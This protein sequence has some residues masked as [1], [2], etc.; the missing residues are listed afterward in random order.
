[1][2]VDNGVRNI[3]K[4]GKTKERD[5]KQKTKKAGSLPRKLNKTILQNNKKVI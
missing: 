3:P 1:M 5:I 2:S 4:T